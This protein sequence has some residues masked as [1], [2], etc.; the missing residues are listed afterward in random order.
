MPSLSMRVP[1]T[2]WRRA[3]TTS[4][5]GWMRMTSAS[6]A[7]APLAFDGATTALMA[8]VVDQL[9]IPGVHLLAL[10]AQALDAEPHLVA[11]LE[12][13]GRRLHAESH[14]GRRAGGDEVARPERHEAAAVR[15]QLGDAEDHRLRAAVLAALAVDV[16]PHRQRL[17]ILDLVGRHHPRPDRAEGV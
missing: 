8:S 10:L 12:E 1:P 2:S 5:F 17:R 14:A 13:H 6:P 9:G 15:D 11:G 16:E 7:A 3:M 4:S